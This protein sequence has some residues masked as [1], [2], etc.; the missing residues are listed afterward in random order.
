MSRAIDTFLQRIRNAVYGREVR[1]SIAS[2]IEQ[3]Y[4][5]AVDVVKVSQTKPTGENVKL[6]V[7]P[8]SDEMKVPTWEEF[9]EA[10]GNT[11]KIKNALNTLVIP[12]TPEMVN[13]RLNANDGTEFDV[14]VSNR[15]ITLDYLPA[16]YLK[17][18]ENNTT[19]G[20]TYIFYYNYENETY[21]Y[22]PPYTDTLPGSVTNIDQSKG[23]H[24]RL[25]STSSGSGRNLV[26][27]QYV[28]ALKDM[29]DDIGDC[30]SI[31]DT[32]LLYRGAAPE[33]EEHLLSYLTSIGI[34][35]TRGNQTW[36][37]KPFENNIALLNLQITNHYTLQIAIDLITGRQAIRILNYND[38]VVDWIAIATTDDR[39]EIIERNVNNERYYQAYSR[40]KEN[41][42]GK[43]IIRFAHITDTHSDGNAWQRFLRYL[44]YVKPSPEVVIHSGDIVKTHINNDYSYMMDNLPNT[45]TLVA[46]GNHE[47]GN[48]LEIGSGGATNVTCKATFIT[49]LG[50][51]YRNLLSI[52]T[53]EDACYYYADI[54][55]PSESKTIRV[56]VLNC[57]DYD[58]LVNGHFVNR[59]KMHF[60]QS[61]INW[62]IQVLS[63]AN[64]NSI[65]V[66][67]VAHESDCLLRSADGMDNPFNMNYTT[68][69][70]TD[71]YT[72]EWVGNP[73]CDIVEAFINGSSVNKTYDESEFQVNV[74]ASFANAGNFVCWFV[75][76]RHSDHIG[77]IPGYKQ[78]VICP[79]NGAMTV[80]ATFCD[81]PRQNGTKTQD[82]FNLYCI[83]VAK[84][85]IGITRIGADVTYSGTDRIHTIVSYVPEQS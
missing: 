58:A 43:D 19:A 39:D 10:T 61:Q 46:I 11:E 40:S 57:Y 81:M 1:E 42:Q 65:P 48:S 69:A 54:K 38:L 9:E 15:W 55:S 34:Y 31:K 23:T 22:K 13:G 83:D 85:T 56:I 72:K 77:F 52:P 64:S 53:A 44:D 4:D 59:A 20:H 71:A 84:K 28:Q 45:P 82:C 73:I 35:V 41:Y 67:I 8:E 70:G 66:C 14:G 49:P 7:K 47:C 63:D 27:N 62:L 24:I 16:E 12:F 17:S 26:L 78:L 74:S 29:Q 75:G 76:H 51:K 18:L 68:S 30:L 79:P 25:Y 50:T 32:S 60:S 2:G 33:N 80:T 37:D 21:V 3:C 6:W 5:D 36:N